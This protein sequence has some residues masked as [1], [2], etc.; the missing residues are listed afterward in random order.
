MLAQETLDGEDAAAAVL[1]GAGGTTDLTHGARAILHGR[2]DVAVAD[3]L[4]VADDHGSPSVN[5]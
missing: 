3:D 1:T 5:G 2:N 4:A